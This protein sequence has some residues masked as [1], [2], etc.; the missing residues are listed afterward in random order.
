MS[1]QSALPPLPPGQ[2]KLND[3][4]MLSL[5]ESGVL[6]YAS[7]H[8]SSLASI[9]SEI[10]SQR[11]PSEAGVPREP[12]VVR[13]SQRLPLA[14]SWTFTGTAVDHVQYAIRHF[15]GELMAFLFK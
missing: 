4:R 1:S 5:K 13:T 7:S 10:A 11:A 9:G 3:Q 8:T 6:P 2:H 15:E 14:R 12:S